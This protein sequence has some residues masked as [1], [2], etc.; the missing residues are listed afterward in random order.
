M[1]RY[2]G[3]FFFAVI[4]LVLTAAGCSGPETD[5]ANQLVGEV[6]Q[7]NIDDD[8]TQAGTL[9]SQA[10][11]EQATG[12]AEV[13]KQSLA[14][15]QERLNAAS[16]SLQTARDKLD[17]AASMNISSEFESYLQSKL[18]AVDASLELVG[19]LGQEIDLILADPN[20]E[21]PDSDKKLSDLAGK[22]EDA[23]KRAT[24]AEAEASKQAA[25]SD[26]IK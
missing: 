6:N 25:Q 5:Q 9:V 10:T 24:D 19:I 12:Q 22:A 11:T 4:V 21:S 26:Q 3:L 16:S 17:Q 18:T 2:A 23:A 8:L 15:A 14:R 7:I 20:M 1:R 13:A